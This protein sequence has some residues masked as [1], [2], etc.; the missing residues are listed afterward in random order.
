MDNIYAYIRGV[1]NEQF[2]R[3]RFPDFSLISPWFPSKMTSYVIKVGGAG[4]LGWFPSLISKKICFDFSWFQLDFNWFLH[5]VYEISFVADP[6]RIYYPWSTTVLYWEETIF[7]VTSHIHGSLI[8][9]PLIILG[10]AACTFVTHSRINSSMISRRLT[11]PRD[12]QFG[13]PAIL[14]NSLASYHSVATIIICALT[15]RKWAWQPKIFGCASYASGW[16]PLYK[17]LDPPL[18][19]GSNRALAFSCRL[20]HPRATFPHRDTG[21]F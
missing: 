11:R 9:T 19:C 13:L 10:G 8:I 7:R 5:K 12:I 1:G 4:G 6:S 15:C 18:V 20:L 16:T 3:T 21:K 2:W 17:F 14:N